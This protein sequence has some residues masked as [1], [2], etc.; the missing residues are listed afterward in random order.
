[1]RLL[2]YIARPIFILCLPLFF[3]SASLA[4]GFNSLW[5]YQYGFEKY[6]V[7]QRTGLTPQDLEKT[8]R[9]LIT[10]FKINSP[11][12]FIQVTVTKDNRSFELF[13]TEEKIHFSDVRQLV[14]LDYRILLI[15]TAIILVYALFYTFWRK[16]IHRRQLARSVIWGS[17]LA[18]A[19]I[20]LLGV[21][22]LLDFDR[23]FLQFHYLAFSNEHWSARGYM[24]QL[25]PGGFWF[26]A[27]LI[28]IGFMAGL[29]VILGL[30]SYL[31][32]RLDKK[33]R[34]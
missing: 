15:S 27:A 3:L 7:S 26:D 1:M 29:A 17:G 23:L 25:F 20:I 33:P 24:L 18:I 16:G 8:A 11:E 14:W 9:G 6:N 12:E 5:L 31:Y 4:W 19:I 21:S 13:T 34:D 32:L 10:Y 30:L 28:C 2:G 22:S